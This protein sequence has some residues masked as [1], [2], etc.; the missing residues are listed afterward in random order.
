MTEVSSPITFINEDLTGLHLPHDDALVISVTI[1]N[2]NVQR[3][4]ID[5]RSSADIL[6]ISA[7][8]KMK[9]EQDKLHLFHS[10]FIEFGG[11]AIKNLGGLNCP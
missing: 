8:K 5:N 7:F 4:L 2:F 10:S 11:G 3:I 6:F 9:I 1:V